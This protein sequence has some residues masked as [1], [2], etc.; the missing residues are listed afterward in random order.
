MKNAGTSL[1]DLAD[2]WYINK[3]LVDYIVNANDKGIIETIHPDLDNGKRAS[4]DG[5]DSSSTKT[6]GNNVTLSFDYEFELRGGNEY[7]Y[8]Q[9]DLTNHGNADARNHIL[10]RVKVSFVGNSGIKFAG[11]EINILDV[12]SMV[13][14][15]GGIGA[16]TKDPTK[17]LGPKGIDDQGNVDI[18]RNVLGG[19]HDFEDEGLT[20]LMT[21]VR[22]GDTTY[23]RFSDFSVMPSQSSD[24]IGALQ[25]NMN[26]TDGH[27]QI[28]LNGASLTVKLNGQTNV[29][30]RV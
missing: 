20:K 19:M 8:V 30:R 22:Y 1:L 18:L 24:F 13:A 11:S 2:A 14:L 12:D 5:L 29:R 27:M 3:A 9:A 10:D 15:A 16:F 23:S 21:G 26:R 6:Y 7:G 28:I 4:A 17:P 25:A